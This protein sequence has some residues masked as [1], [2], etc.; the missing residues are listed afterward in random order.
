MINLLGT[1]VPRLARPLFSDL[2]WRVPTTERVLFLT[3]DDGP[4]VH[5]PRLLE[6]LAQY[7]A[8]ALFFLLG[9]NVQQFPEMT[10]PMIEA[11]HTLGNHSF[12]HPD[13]WRSPWSEVRDELERTDVLLAE[14]QGR[15]VRWL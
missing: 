4:S 7:E 3:F 10:C 13:A 5:T 6:T 9:K 12:S 1:H 2:L 11:G 15:P 14:K 8:P